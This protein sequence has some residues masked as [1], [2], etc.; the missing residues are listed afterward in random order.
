[1]IGFAG[2]QINL[3]AYVGNNPVV[4]VDPSGLLSPGSKCKDDCGPTINAPLQASLAAMESRF[5]GLNWAQRNIACIGWFAINGWDI[6]C[7]HGHQEWII[8]Y[9][10]LTCATPNC[11]KTVQVDNQCFYAGSVNYAER[12]QIYRMCCPKYWWPSPL[13][14]EED[15]TTL[16]LCIR[17]AIRGTTRDQ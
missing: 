10:S 9:S 17:R 5:Q 4:K 11:N 8:D 6:K 13:T 2:G 12:G 15:V 7:P 16:I 1:M 14:C 3:Y